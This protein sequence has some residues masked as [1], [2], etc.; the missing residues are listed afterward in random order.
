[1]PNRVIRDG[2]LTSEKVDKLSE[3]AELFY[4]RLMSVVDDFGRYSAHP[5][6]LRSSCYPLRID[7]KT[8]RDMESYL[9]ECQSAGLLI[10]Y[11]ADGKRYLEMSD[12]RQRLRVMSSKCPSPDGQT[13]VIC[14]SDDGVNRSR[15][16]NEEEEEEE[17][18]ENVEEGTGEKPQAATH[19]QRKSFSKKPESRDECI[20]FCCE[21]LDLPEQDG[22]WLWDKWQGNGFTVNGKPMKSWKHTAGAW[23]GQGYFP[24]QKMAN[25]QNGQRK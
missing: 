11:E 5:T 4:R 10:V 16:R 7:A 21:T 9:C 14:Q 23:R 18:E 19:S 15:S 12:F 25:H 3:P 13:S 22:H 17:V 6:L 24:S 20:T 2:I 1:M 8:N